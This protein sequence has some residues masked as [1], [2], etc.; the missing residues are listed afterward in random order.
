MET[1][2]MDVHIFCVQACYVEEVLRA[3][4]VSMD[5]QKSEKVVNI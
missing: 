1:V 5:S 4:E 3:A 2:A